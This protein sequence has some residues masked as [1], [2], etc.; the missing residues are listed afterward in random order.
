MLWAYGLLTAIKP[1][2]V[3]LN[4]VITAPTT[5]IPTTTSSA[6]ITTTLSNVTGI[7]NFVSKF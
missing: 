3:I 1:P 2:D 5:E 7:G 4:S 6:N